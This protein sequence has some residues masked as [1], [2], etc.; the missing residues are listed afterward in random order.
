MSRWTKV[1]RACFY[2]RFSVKILNVP[3][4]SSHK[5]LCT[6]DSS[7]F[8]ADYAVTLKWV[9]ENKTLPFALWKVTGP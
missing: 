6:D 2:G 7:V 1:E 4:Q 8:L 9:K 5:Y 3:F